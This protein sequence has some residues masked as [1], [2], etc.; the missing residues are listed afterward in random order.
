MSDIILMPQNT[1]LHVSV[2]QKRRKTSSLQKFNKSICNR[3]FF[4]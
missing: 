3:Q 1:L 2:G 4:F